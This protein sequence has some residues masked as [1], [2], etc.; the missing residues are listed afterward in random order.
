MGLAVEA[1]KN[2]IAS[3]AVLGEPKY[4]LKRAQDVVSF[5]KT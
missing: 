4:A 2:V 5:F 1:E 3:R